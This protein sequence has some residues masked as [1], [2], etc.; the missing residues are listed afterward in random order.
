MG[1]LVSHPTKAPP[2]T[3]RELEKVDR[4]DSAPD[5]VSAAMVMT[6]VVWV[7]LTNSVSPG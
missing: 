4:P 2:C 7:I 5:A 1:L 3:F 6:S